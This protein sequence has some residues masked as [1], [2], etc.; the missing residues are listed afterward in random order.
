MYM[1]Q[2]D[3]LF[4]IEIHRVMSEYFENKYGEREVTNPKGEVE[5]QGTPKEIILKVQKDR[6]VQKLNRNV[7]SQPDVF[8]N[9]KFNLRKLNEL[10]FHYI[11]SGNVDALVDNVL[12]NYDWLITKTKALSV[13]HVIEDFNEVLM[14]WGSKTL[15]DLTPEI[16]RIR[17]CLRLCKPALNMNKE[18]DKNQFLS[19][20]FAHEFLGRMSVLESSSRGPIRSILQKCREVCQSREVSN[21]MPANTCYPSPSQALRCSLFGHKSYPTCLQYLRSGMYLLSGSNDKTVR[22]WDTETDELA[23]NFDEHRGQIRSICTIEYANVCASI[24]DDS[25][26]FL[27]DIQS[28]D[29]YAHFEQ[30]VLPQSEMTCHLVATEYA[31][32]NTRYIFCAA[33]ELK[34]W[35]LTTYYSLCATTTQQ[36]SKLSQEDIMKKCN[37]ATLKE[38][39]NLGLKV[40]KLKVSIKDR[41]LA[42]GY[43]SGLLEVYGIQ[44]L[45]LCCEDKVLHSSSLTVIQAEYHSSFLRG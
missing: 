12:S 26:I 18:E 1:S 3:I 29:V 43:D 38:I 11:F 15:K 42:V 35:D 27:W 14:F 37:V 9:R 33:K 39:F 31:S 32:S 44:R 22:V 45:K 17:D 36:P 24:A 25:Q 23:M 40:T 16:R 7:R 4:K 19:N 34:V 30:E 10:P 2:K 5:K 8:S 13:Q 41:Y 21:L 20:N 28:G 6:G